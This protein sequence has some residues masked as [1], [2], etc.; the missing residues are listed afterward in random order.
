MAEYPDILVLSVGVSMSGRK[1][2]AGHESVGLA[3][4]PAVD[5]PGF[6]SRPL[7]TTAMGNSS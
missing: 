5:Q 1:D 6:L 2:P 3:V 7:V 4:A